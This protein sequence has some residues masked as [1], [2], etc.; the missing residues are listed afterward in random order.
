[1]GVDHGQSPFPSPGPQR[2]P[3]LDGNELAGRRL[4]A[5]ALAFE[6]AKETFWLTGSANAT[7]AAVDGGNTESVLWFSSEETAETLFKDDALTIEA[8]DPAKFAKPAG[9]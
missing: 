4:H 2:E 8:I 5:K 9:R 7:E 1:M 6:T 3:Q